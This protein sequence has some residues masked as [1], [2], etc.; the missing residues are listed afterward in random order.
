MNEKKRVVIIGGGFAGLSSARYLSKFRKLFDVT[1]LDRR[2]TTDFLPLL[3]DVIG[4]NV[5]PAFLQGDLEECMTKMH[6]RF[7]NQEVSSISLDE[8]RVVTNTQEITYDYLLI[9][10]GTESNF[11]GNT[12]LQKVSYKLDGVSDITKLKKVLHL[13][14]EI[15]F[16]IAGGG[17]TGIEIATNLRRTMPDKTIVIVDPAPEILGILPPEM[18]EYARKN[19][20]NLNITVF[21]G[22]TVQS[23]ENRSI[24]LSNGHILENAVLIWTA[25]VKTADYIQSLPLEKNKQGRILVD[26]FLRVN[27]SCFAAGD[28]ASIDYDGKPLRM[29]VQFSLTAGQCAAKNIMRSVCGLSLKQFKPLDLGY[30]VPMANNKSCGIV[31]G[32]HVRGLL[33]TFLH[34][35]MSIVRSCGFRNRVGLCLDI[36]RN[37]VKKY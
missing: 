15:Q 31:F 20:Q 7:I 8:K 25:G 27:N 17:Y 4:R 30:V 24:T 11:Y 5:N 1:L 14:N 29:A 34:F 10:S 28:A 13:E 23:L 18:K 37:I 9:A 26:R 12:S 33:P 22:T 21:T 32:I 16:V 2:P 35:F 19:V 36:L 3:P 6:A